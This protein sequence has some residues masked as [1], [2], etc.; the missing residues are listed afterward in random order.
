MSLGLRTDLFVRLIC[1][2]DGFLDREASWSTG[3]LPFKVRVVIGIGARHLLV[4]MLGVGMRVS[5]HL[6]RE[7][8]I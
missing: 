5:S 3:A 6:G 7:R 8:T 4:D 2:Y 1:E